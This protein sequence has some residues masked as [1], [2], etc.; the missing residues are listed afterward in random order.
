LTFAFCNARASAHL[1]AVS[2][3][4]FAV[5]F[6]FILHFDQW[7][8]LAEYLCN[9]DEVAP[10]SLWSATTVSL[11]QQDPGS[12]QRREAVLWGESKSLVALQTCPLSAVSCLP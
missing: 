10:L 3:E 4:L 2:R 8:T 1:P 12:P 7:T 5:S 6:P 11:Q 9:C